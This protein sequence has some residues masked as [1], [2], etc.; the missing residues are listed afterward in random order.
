MAAPRKPTNI[1]KLSNAFKKNPKRGKARENE[2]AP[3]GGIGACPQWL[4][5]WKKECAEIWDE[6]VADSAPGVLTSS[7]K[8]SF[9]LLVRYEWEFRYAWETM[10]KTRKSEHK[11]LLRAFGFNR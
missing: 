11:I 8:G 7:D 3:P 10:S 5:D 1:H 6:Y 9:A 2:P 4:R